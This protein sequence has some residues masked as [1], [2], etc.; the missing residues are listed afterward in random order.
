MVEIKYG[1]QYEIIDLAGQ[2]VSEAREQYASE[3][4]IPEKAKAKY[5]ESLQRDIEY[6]DPLRALED[7]FFRDGRTP[8]TEERLR[9]LL[10][11]SGLQDAVENISSE[12]KATEGVGQAVEAQ[13]VTA[14]SAT[15]EE[16]TLTPM[17]R[18][19][20]LMEKKQ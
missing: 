17:E 6:T 15:P 4:G 7:I 3:F 18:M 19:K 10:T 8:E 5:L 9:T 2:T 16:K 20:L 12:A 13:Q 14:P 1:N 11:A